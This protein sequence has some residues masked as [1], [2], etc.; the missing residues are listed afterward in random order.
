MPELADAPFLDLFDPALEIDPEPV[1]ADLR[2][3]TSVARTPLG[4]AVI[5]RE[6]IRGLLADPRVVTSIPHLIALQG[7]SDGWVFD[8]VSSSVISTE[9]SDHTRLR[10]LVSRSFTP[11]AAARHRPMMRTL[12]NQLVDGFSSTGRCDFVADFADHYP[13][14]VICEVLGTPTRRP[15]PVRRAGA[16][17]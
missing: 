6:E 4:A 13:V 3:R 17:R 5:R 12:V 1:Y 15:R 8:M 11:G 2:A 10:R 9:G 7:V 14:Q 16:T